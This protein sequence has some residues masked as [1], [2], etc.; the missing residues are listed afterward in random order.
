MTGKEDLDMLTRQYLDL[1][2]EH[3][4]SCL[5]TPEAASAMAR[6]LTPFGAEGRAGLAGINHPA[7]RS[8]AD[9]KPAALPTASH[10]GDVR[11]DELEER[12]A[13]LERRLAAL[14]RGIETGAAR[15]ARGSTRKI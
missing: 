3:W 4:A 1:W 11:A 14:E 13:V 10:A 8:G 6:L 9:D 15:K 12:I 2:V 5:A 7:G